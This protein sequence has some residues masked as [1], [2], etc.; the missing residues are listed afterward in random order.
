LKEVRQQEKS[1]NPRKGARNDFNVSLYLFPAT[2]RDTSVTLCDEVLAYLL[3][4]NCN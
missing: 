3:A 1:G 4:A 2:L